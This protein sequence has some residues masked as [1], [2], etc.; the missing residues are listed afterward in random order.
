[1][2]ILIA[3]DEALV[4]IGLKSLLE[5]YNAHHEIIEAG[6]GNEAL[7]KF[8][9][10]SPPLVFVDINMPGMDGLEFVNEAK[11][12]NI[13]SRFI[14][15]TCHSDFAHMRK[16]IQIGLDDYI[17]KTDF[18]EAELVSFVK[19]TES[20]F[21]MHL[22]NETRLDMD[23]ESSAL[24]D[25]FHKVAQG[26]GF[27][28]SLLHGS[29]IKRGMG[30]VFH[31]LV[32]SL[33]GMMNSDE[34]HGRAIRNIIDGLV[35]EYGAG[36]VC[37]FSD[38]EFF[39]TMSLVDEESHIHCLS[40]FSG[41]LIACLK[42]YLNISVTIGIDTNVDVESFGEAC[43]RTMKMIANRSREAGYYFYNRIETSNSAC[44]FANAQEPQGKYYIEIV[45]KAKEFMRKNIDKKLSLMEV[46]A[47]VNVSPCHF[48]KMFK[49]ATGCNFIDYYMK[50]RI[51]KVK[52]IIDEGTK[53]TAAAEIIGYCN[54]SY[55]SKLFKKIEGVT[56]EEYK[57]MS[58]AVL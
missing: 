28:K 30:N 33:C 53:I 52:S 4:R 41:R 15:I 23:A 8:L 50:L 48:S 12:T 45:E 29:L 3:D 25:E 42:N 20:R 44:A 2:K 10:F 18:N 11:K 55:F 13:D 26:L 54:Y 19:Q 31:L 14:V 22:A 34:Q 17:I 46:A 57:R 5:G 24:D 37:K 38:H 21:G 6:D 51:G 36:Y 1:M 39:I 32:V 40:D 16:A 43:N 27:D 9:E 49:L 35:G 47:Y 7:R 58:K 56:P